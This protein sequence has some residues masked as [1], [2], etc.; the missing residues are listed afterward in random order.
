MNHPTL[1]PPVGITLDTRELPPPEPLVQAL[2]A[3]D[4]LPQG[5]SLRLLIAREPH[6][7]YQSLRASGHVWKT[8]LQDDYSFQILIWHPAP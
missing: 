2:E 7:L 3:L 5:Q 4:D 8:D 6:P 1:P